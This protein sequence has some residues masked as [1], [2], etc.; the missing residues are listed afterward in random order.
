MFGPA[1]ADAEDSGDIVAFKVGVGFIGVEICRF[2]L[3]DLHFQHEMAC[4]ARDISIDEY[5]SLLHDVLHGVVAE[6]ISIE[7][8]FALVVDDV[9]VGQE[10]EGISDVLMLHI[11]IFIPH[12]DY[13]R[14]VKH[15]L[16]VLFL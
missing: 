9:G 11:V 14:E 3:I 8:G 16:E 6:V 5:F 13:L 1:C 10:L 15:I 7:N 4:K 2:V 12:L